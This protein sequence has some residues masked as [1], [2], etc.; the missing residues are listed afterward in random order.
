VALVFCLSEDRPLEEIGL[1]LALCSLRRHQPE[2]EAVIYQPNASPGLV[3]WLEG[4][5]R[6]RLV[7]GRPGGAAGWNCKPHVLLPLLEAGHAEVVWLDGDILLTRPCAPLLQKS[8]SEELIVS[9][10]QAAAVAPQGTEPRTRGWGLPVGR[11]YPWT[12]NSCV[13][14]VTAHHVPLLRRWQ[15]LL[16]SPEYL[17]WQAGPIGDRPFHMHGDQ[18]ALGALVGAA[19]FRDL[20]VRFLRTGRDVI[21][22]GGALA[23]SVGERVRGLFAPKPT[24]LHGQ[25]TKP[26]WVFDPASLREHRGWFLTYRRWLQ[27]V[28]PYVAEARKYR[29]E[30]GGLDRPWLD[31]W[32]WFGGLNR[33]AGFGHHALRGLPLSAAA[34]VLTAAGRWARRPRAAR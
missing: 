28:S 5:P 2:S 20:P 14:R 24:F 33:L 22:A 15:E 34:A 17:R 27:E 31:Y 3:A 11:T 1:R 13:L 10:E 26:W 12:V 25:G 23:Y 9:Q 21:H 16:A 8:P 18:E 29:G 6:V 30:L 7:P 32:S 19:E 4:F